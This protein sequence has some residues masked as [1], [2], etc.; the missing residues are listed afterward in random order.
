MSIIK[1]YPH[2]APR[3]PRRHR[4]SSLRRCP[5]ARSRWWRS[6]RRETRAWSIDAELG[7]VVIEIYQRIAAG[8]SCEDIAVSSVTVSGCRTSHGASG[9]FAVELELIA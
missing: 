5:F 4:R 6:K 7:P 2:P 8:E 1:T 9:A 3:D